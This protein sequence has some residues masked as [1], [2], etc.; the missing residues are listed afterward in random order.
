MHKERHIRTKDCERQINKNSQKP[1]PYPGFP[2]TM[3]PSRRGIRKRVST[4]VEVKLY[5][6][7]PLRKWPSASSRPSR[8]FEGNARSMASNI[9]GRGAREKIG[10]NDGTVTMLLTHRD[11]RPRCDPRQ[12]LSGARATNMSVASTEI[13]PMYILCHFDK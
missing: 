1:I 2:L 3:E 12:D 5:H 4:R 7:S 13:E 10:C 9:W 8:Q 11:I 6:A